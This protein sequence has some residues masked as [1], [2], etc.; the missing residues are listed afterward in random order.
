MA[1]AYR[2]GFTLMEL[3]V[4]MGIIV[5]MTAM[6]LPAISKFLDGQSLQQSGRIV[7]SAFNDARRAAITQR[8]K[9]YLIFFRETDTATGEMRYGIRRYRDRFG[10]E[11]DAHLL[12]PSTQFDLMP[13][14]GSVIPALTGATAPTQCIGRIRGLRLPVYEPLPNETD[15][16]LFLNRQIQP[17]GNNVWLEFK[18]D[19]TVR[20]NSTTEYEQA[21]TDARIF[22]INQ[23]FEVTQQSSFDA[24]PDQVDMNLREVSDADNV[25]KRCFMDLDP[26]TGRLTIRVIQLLPQ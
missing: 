16:V 5:L 3:L 18:K 24:L 8:T 25:D 13:A 4:V 15:P 12:L 1:R 17:G 2:R 22:D 26:N 11:G 21:P 14:S 19:G 20:L 6:S 9:Q 23:T 7:Q 10:Y